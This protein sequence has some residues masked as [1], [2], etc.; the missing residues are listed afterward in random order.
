[1]VKMNSMVDR[2]SKTDR[3]INHYESI[4]I[5]IREEI[6]FRI[7]Q[8][9]S[10]SNY[11]AVSLGT[12]VTAAFLSNNILVLLIAPFASIYFTS[13]IM[14]SYEIHVKIMTYLRDIIEPELSR[15]CETP[16]EHE[17]EYF[18]TSRYKS[19]IRRHFYVY[20]MYLICL[21]VPIIVYLIE[22]STWIAPLL[23]LFISW[24]LCCWIK[25]RND[26]VTK[27]SENKN[28]EDNK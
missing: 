24:G 12:I 11:L 20:S 13:M 22:P 28:E 8:R 27:S 26:E 19:G 14:H 15:L 21:F 16:C 1:M 5:S 9:D 3:A 23:C 4:R 25:I 2:L 7:G 17:W 18:Y 10:F 6:L